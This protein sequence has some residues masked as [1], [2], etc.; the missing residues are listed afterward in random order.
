MEGYRGFSGLTRACSS[1]PGVWEAK[2]QIP[3]STS[4][5][6][7]GVQVV[8]TS[9]FLFAIMK[10]KE[11]HNHNF[12]SL[13]NMESPAEGPALGSPNPWE[14]AACWDESSE[15]AVP[16]H[17]H[18]PCCLPSSHPLKGQSSRLFGWGIIMPQYENPITT[19]NYLQLLH[20][21]Q[22]CL[23]TWLV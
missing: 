2:H 23:Y 13:H 16:L 21:Q 11:D 18:N 14:A 3:Q 20:L 4:P 19:L 15:T 10:P 1:C 9:Y 22:V 8:I 12:H 5:I 17:K 7:E 6:A